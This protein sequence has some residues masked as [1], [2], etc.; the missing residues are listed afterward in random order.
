M[1]S[2]ENVSPQDA[3][4]AAVKPGLTTQPAYGK[5]FPEFTRNSKQACLVSLFPSAVVVFHTEPGW[6]TLTDVI[7]VR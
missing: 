3:Q 5:V 4:P 7:E 1:S 6:L 2:G